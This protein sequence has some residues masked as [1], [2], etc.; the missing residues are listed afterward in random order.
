MLSLQLMFTEEPSL[1]VKL[2][3]SGKSQYFQYC[4]I[5]AKMFKQNLQQGSSCKNVDWGIFWP[6]FS[7]YAQLDT[8]LHGNEAEGPV[9][10][11]QVA[12]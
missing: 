6:I 7:H 10:R 9:G 8:S 4:S 12:R 5:W 1:T 2:K 3:M 11:K